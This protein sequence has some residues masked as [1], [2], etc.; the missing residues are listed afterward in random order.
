[1]QGLLII[2]N[3]INK[4][5]SHIYI[6]DTNKVNTKERGINVVKQYQIKWI[7]RKRLGIIKSNI[8]L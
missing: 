4:L 5:A 6:W 1:M 2:E 8:I 7:Q 3:Y